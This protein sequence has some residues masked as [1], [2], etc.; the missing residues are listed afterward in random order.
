MIRP[1]R[2]CLAASLT[3]AMLLPGASIAQQATH[4][5]EQ[6]M[7]PR[8]SPHDDRDYR[9]LTLDNGLTALLVSDSE[10]DKAAA[11]LNVD[12]GSA[13]DPDDLPGLAH[14]LEHMLFLGT[15]S[16]PEADAYQSY[17][18][19]HGGQHNA[20]TASQDT[21]YFFSIEPDALSGALDRF[22]RFFVNPLFNANRLE[23]ERKVVHSEYIARKRNE[24]RRRNDV[25]D[26]LLNPENPTTG[27][28]VGS[29]ET[30]ADRPEGEPGLRER[31]QS[32]YTDHY[33]ANVMHLAVVAPQPLD[34]LESLVRDNFTDVPDRGL[35]RPTIEEPLVD[36]SSLPTAAKLQSLRDSRQLS[37]YFPVPDPI[38]DYRH[39]PASYL[40]SLLG[41]EGDGSLLAVLRK[42]G[43]A[44]GLSAGVSRG[45]G[46]HALFQVDISLTPEGAEHQ[47]R[48]QASLFAAIRAIRNGGVEAWR[49]D[50]QAQLAEQAFRFQQHGSALNDAMR[51]SMNLSRYPVED[52]N[53][54]PYRM[55][56]FDTS[57]IDTWLSAL[58]PD[59]MLRL[60]SG[61]EVEGERTSPWFD[62]PWSPVALGDDDTQPLAGLSLP[63]PNPYIAENLELL[64][65]QDEIPQKRLDEPGFEFWHMRD[66]SFDTP[67][68][69]WRF[70]LQN[71][72]ASHD[73][74]KAALS[75]LLAGWLQDSL[76]EALYPAR[77]AG[78][79]FEAYAHARGITL[80]FSGWRD[81]QDRL[82]ERVLEQLQ[83]GKIEADSV[84]RVRE[85][86]RRNWRNAPQDDLY[87]QAGRTLTE[88]LIS[89]QWSPETLLEASKDLDTQALRDFREAFLAD[90]HL[91]SMA[92]GDLG[93]EQAERLARHVADK[94]APA[95]SHEA[96]PQLV[97]LRASNDLPTLTP[98]TKRDESL[99]MRYLQGE[100][101]ALATQARL[102]VL[103]R[104]LETPFYQQLRTEQ[105]L[106]YVV[107]AGYRP[108]LDA[109]GI[110]FLVQSPD[111][112]S[113][114]IQSRIDAFI[115]D[116]GKRLD[117]VQDSDL[118]AYRQAVRDDL[119]QRDTSL[120]GRTNR[121]WQALALEDTGFDHRSRLA[122]RVMDV[123]PEALRE[124]WRD[125]AQGPAVNIVH[126][127][128]DSA[129][130][131]LSLKADLTPLPKQA[132]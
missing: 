85:S 116:F 10:A 5:A 34:E 30:L 88:A 11:S 128:G 104:L 127:P 95:L 118:A 2:P 3:L 52:V 4:E 61:P 123:T 44:D 26:Q 103:G 35:S 38:T 129:S 124:T 132:R 111:T 6:A 12:V 51:L 1:S 22:S 66:A 18:T 16:Y 72:E 32:F 68:V 17:L 33:G 69:E 92:V 76:N 47:S 41:H 43:W 102:S 96:I 99:V 19:R 60:Y 53:Y 25:L 36:K 45:D 126:D 98:D 56:G 46:Q 14:Y 39:K 112:D 117:D 97:T 48:I 73:A 91:E 84:E 114:T 125:L 94:L 28:S 131:V 83:H 31:I 65:Q 86:L 100:D 130:N 82:I 75:R 62:T 108:L 115:D 101:R 121:L 77:L 55:D 8:V 49:Y 113:Q 93:T 74:R 29:L 119:L 37:F 58:R 57:R 107:N 23:N 42:A 70:S 54:A 7:T 13:Q 27:F 81:R 15:E 120:S 80:S 106:G 110:T 63:E 122:E 105:Q 90:L 67:K 89:P 24:G 9:V 20:F 59:N 78:H 71:P 21:N 64:G 79:G 50:E 40:A 109:P 87:R